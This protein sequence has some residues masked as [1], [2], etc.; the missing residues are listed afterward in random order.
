MSDDPDYESM[1]ALIERLERDS[2]D[3]R[4]L[5]DD[6]DV[7]AVERNAK[8]VAAAAR[9]LRKNLPPELVEE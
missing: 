4:T 7:P 3:L 8:R 5:A 6:G 9:M 2:R 1:V